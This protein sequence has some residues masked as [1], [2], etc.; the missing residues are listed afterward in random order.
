MGLT[1]YL[2]S[3]E[4]KAKEDSNIKIMVSENDRFSSEFL[5]T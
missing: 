1:V 3:T 5:D 2:S 4:E